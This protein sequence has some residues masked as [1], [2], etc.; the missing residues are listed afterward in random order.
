MITSCGREAV[1]VVTEDYEPATLE[2]VTHEP[3]EI[4][5]TEFT[6]LDENLE[7]PNEEYEKENKEYTEYIPEQLPYDYY[8]YEGT[9]RRTVTQDAGL[10]YVAEGFNINVGV[11]RYSKLGSRWMYTGYGSELIPVWI[12]HRYPWGINTRV[13]FYCAI[14]GVERIPAIFEDANDFLSGVARVRAL[15]MD[16]GFIDITGEWAIRPRFRPGWVGAYFYDGVVPVRTRGATAY[17]WGFTDTSGT[18]IFSRMADGMSALN[19]S[20]AATHGGSIIDRE[21][22]RLAF[23]P[24]TY[25]FNLNHQ[26]TSYLGDGLF[27]DSLLLVG[28][29]DGL[30]GVFSTRG[31]VRLPMSYYRI[32]RISDTRFLTL[33]RT[34]IYDVRY[35]IFDIST[36]A[37]IHPVYIFCAIER[38]NDGV[39]VVE[40]NGEF[41]LMDIDGQLVIPL[42]RY[43]EIRNFGGG[44]IGVRDNNLW[45]FVDNTGRE[46]TPAIYHNVKPTPQTDN[47]LGN[48]LDYPWYVSGMANVQC[49]DTFLWGIV[50]NT[51]QAIFALE[52]NYIRYFRGDFTVANINGIWHVIN[53]SHDIAASFEYAVLYQLTE[54]LFIYSKY[55]TEVVEAYQNWSF[56]N[57]SNITVYPGEFGII[58]I[59][60]DGLQRPNCSC[61]EAQAIREERQAE[62]EAYE[63]YQVARFPLGYT[64][65]GGLTS[66]VVAYD[67]G[68]VFAADDVTIN[69]PSQERYWQLGSTHMN[70]EDGSFLMPVWTHRNFMYPHNSLVGF[71]CTITGE[72]RIPAIFQN[73]YDFTNGLAKV[74]YFGRYGFI[75]T[76]GEWVIPPLHERNRIGIFHEGLVRVQC[77]ETG[78]WGFLNTEGQQAIPLIYSSVSEFNAS[79]TAIGRTATGDYIINRYGYRKTRLNIPN[80][81][82]GRT[83]YLGDGLLQVG[84]N[85]MVGVVDLSGEIII[86]IMYSRIERICETYFLLSVGTVS[87][88]T[89]TGTHIV[90]NIE[91]GDETQLFPGNTEITLRTC[92]HGI[93]FHDGVAIATR[94]IPNNSTERDFALIDI[95]GEIIIPFGQYSFMEHLGNGLIRVTVTHYPW[96]SPYRWRNTRWSLIDS[97]GTHIVSPI[98]RNIWP[99]RIYNSWFDGMLVYPF[100]SNISGVANVQCAETF[101]WGVV[102]YTG[103]MVFEPEFNSISYFRGDFTV[104]NVGGRYYL[105]GMGSQTLIGGTWHVIN[106]T[107]ETVA[108]FEYAI[109]AQ[110]TENLFIFADSVIQNKMGEWLDGFGDYDDFHSV[111]PIGFGIISIS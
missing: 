101:L 58:S 51:G 88:L 13:G 12:N 41:G 92:G 89:G 63:A 52:F 20:G 7:N 35:S 83:R 79:G 81:S 84:I 14:T 78:Y 17:F 16:Y 27:G 33:G 1:T 8:F 24:G 55:A 15:D 109:V 26:I 73:A 2:V 91:T 60:G 47:F 68:L 95:N 25:P 107:G 76:Y 86:P 40:R 94:R 102:D 38:F 46:I 30:K 99:S 48:R 82:H 10:I 53:R 80:M 18:R 65:G 105:N 72:E 42:G 49:V 87:H 61:A 108:S 4:I 70:T 93:T 57:F 6:V 5:T 31:G 54:T 11:P 59:L 106:R 9:I 36:W 19:A 69:V 56:D 28:N 90:L 67:T 23:L 3:Q 75:N 50:D 44:L 34:S 77:P 97:T 96:G 104:A 71:R 74:R 21:G 110:L 100:P 37:R 22:N 45:G 64:H 62:Q 39:A 43:T 111:W 29:N 32:E 85:N 103:R 98:Y 66:R